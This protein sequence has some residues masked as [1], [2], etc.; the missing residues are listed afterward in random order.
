MYGLETGLS[1]NFSLE[2]EELDC[3][4]SWSWFRFLS[5]KYQCMKLNN[6]NIWVQCI[7]MTGRSTI[8]WLLLSQP[9][10]QQQTPESKCQSSMAQAL[11]AAATA[12][13]LCSNTDLLYRHLSS[14]TIQPLSP[15]QNLIQLWLTVKEH[16]CK[17][18]D[19]DGEL[20]PTRVINCKKY[21]WGKFSP[22]FS[23]SSLRFKPFKV[24]VSTAQN[25]FLKAVTLI[26]IEHTIM[27][28]TY[29][30]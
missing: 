30:A 17:P 15:L 27:Y 22:V 1:Y 14:S 29:F 2:F 16:W 6:T 25:L 8:N 10:L 11:D 5:N 26:W 9:I 24:S 20:L 18:H 19:S 7:R 13:K 4:D 23:N 21:S 12:Y 3:S 28:E